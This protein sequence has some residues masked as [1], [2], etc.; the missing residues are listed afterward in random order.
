M[1]Q[2]FTY[3]PSNYSDEV[4]LSNLTPTR[5]FLNYEHHSVEQLRE[6]YTHH[7]KFYTQLST[8]F[9]TI[10]EQLHACRYREGSVNFPAAEEEEFEAPKIYTLAI[11]QKLPPEYIEVITSAKSSITALLIQSYPDSTVSQFQHAHFFCNY[12]NLLCAK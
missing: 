12:R 6:R 11:I 8:L 10:Y 3:C 7:I 4:H 1:S 2:V 5:F 9:S